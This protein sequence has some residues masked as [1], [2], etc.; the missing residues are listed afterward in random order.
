MQLGDGARFGHP[1]DDLGDDVGVERAGGDVVEEEQRTCRLHEHVADAVVDDVVAEAADATEPRRQL[2]LRADAVGRGDEDRVVHRRDR[3]RREGTAEAADAADDLGAV[4]AFDG[5]AHLG[6]GSVALGDV[7]AGG[8]VRRQDGARRPPADVAAVLHAGEVDVLDRRVR[9]LPGGGEVVAEASDGEHPA[10]ARAAVTH[11]RR[12][13]QG[14]VEL[15]V[16]WQRHGVAGARLGRVASGG[17][18][19]RCRR[20]PR[21]IDSSASAMRPRVAARA[22]AARSPSR[23]GSSAC[24]SGSPKRTLYSTRRGPSAVSISPA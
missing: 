23:S 8:G 9:P 1:A 4:G 16:G 22:I 18:R 19:P 5:M 14:A 13:E 15:L 10:A 6:D 17:E 2:D 24:A 12:E 21:R 20:R 11:A 3:L 7:D